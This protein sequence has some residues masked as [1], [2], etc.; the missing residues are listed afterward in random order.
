MSHQED[1]PPSGLTRRRIRLETG[2]SLDVTTG[3]APDGAPILLLHGFPESGRTWRHQLADLAPQ[4][5]VAAP[6]QR[7]FAGSEKPPEVSAYAVSRL[8]ADVFTLAD[9]L[10]FGRFVLAGHDWGGA[11]AWAAALKHPERLAGLVIANA[12]HPYVF[13]QLLWSDPNQR[14]ASRYILDYRRSGMA[15]E[16][17]AGGLEAFLE[18]SV[19]SHLP[20]KLLT[21]AVRAAYLEEWSQPGALE[22]MLNWYAA[23]P[24][25]VPARDDPGPRPAWLDR[26]FPQVAVPVL[27]VWGRRDRALLPAQLKDLP[28]HV[29]DLRIVEVDAGHFVTWEKPQAVTSAIRG[30]LEERLSAG[31]FGGAN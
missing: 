8:V 2:V 21:S 25:A 15:A 20:S 29:P 26:P 7:G 19:G 17:R 11:V 6:D 22:A 1:W 4:F 14:D 12:P 16:I 13:Q 5:R 9:A 3:G 28:A 30:F 10:G 27:V 31:A 23:S 24:L 18:R